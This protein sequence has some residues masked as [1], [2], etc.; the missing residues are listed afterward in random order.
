[1]GCYLVEALGTRPGEDADENRLAKARRK[2]L[3]H[4]ACAVY[5]PRPAL[6]DWGACRRVDK[7][8][9][10]HAPG[11]LF[12]HALEL[13]WL[14]DLLHLARLG[15]C[16]VKRNFQPRGPDASG[17]GDVR[18]VLGG[19]GCLSGEAEDDVVVAHKYMCAP[20][21]NSPFSFVPDGH[22]HVWAM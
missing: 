18:C 10:R 3:N 6:A 7:E 12:Q 17:P 22:D 16:Q 2:V 11:S 13:L 15:G 19:G 4:R 14:L 8:D 9:A 5:V 21:A 20:C 1:L